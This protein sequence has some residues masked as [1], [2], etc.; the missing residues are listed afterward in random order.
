MRNIKYRMVDSPVGGLLLAGDEQAIRF[1]LFRNGRKPTAP[2]PSWVPDDS[3][4]GSVIAEAE[5]ELVSYFA[6]KLRAFAVPVAP[7]GTEFQRGVW[8]QLQQ[9]P[10]GET[11]SYG[12]IARRLAKPLA[13][14]AVG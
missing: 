1:L 7:D 11:V 9:I 6:G 12:E 8:Q 13:V 14:R 4:R 2:D 5:R 3:A 10:Y